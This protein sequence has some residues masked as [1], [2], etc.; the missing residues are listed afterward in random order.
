MICTEFQHRELTRVGYYTYPLS[1]E[2]KNTTN[3]IF[4]SVNSVYANI[5]EQEISDYEIDPPLSNLITCRFNLYNLYKEE[6]VEKF[7][8]K[9][10]S[11]RC[12]KVSVSPR[13]SLKFK[14]NFKLYQNFIHDCFKKLNE[15]IFKDEFFVVN[16]I[17]EYYPWPKE[18]HNL[19]IPRMGFHYDT[20]ILSNL[21]SSCEGLVL[22]N[23]TIPN[24]DLGVVL[25]GTGQSLFPHCF[26]GVNTDTI[27]KT[28]Y[29][30]ASFM[31]KGKPQ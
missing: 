11:I 20:S 17:V 3:S 24:R 18:F 31:L 2:V 19:Q 9:N 21:I 1:E 13:W 23:N 14:Q 26:H 12:K 28:R 16:Y 27:A 15:K 10:T 30:I 5:D 8:I 6:S 25:T 4:N 29:T 7:Y 22:A